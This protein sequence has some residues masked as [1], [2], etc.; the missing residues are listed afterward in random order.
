MREL[1]LAKETV[2]KFYRAE[3]VGD[4]LAASLAGTVLAVGAAPG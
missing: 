3:T 4:V 1:G 2:R